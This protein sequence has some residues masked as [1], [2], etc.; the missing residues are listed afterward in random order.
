MTYDAWKTRSPD[1]G[2]PQIALCDRCNAIGNIAEDEY[3]E[4]VC[5]S[6]VDN[7]AE[8]AYERYC[9][10]FHDGGSTRFNSLRDQQIA[11]MKLK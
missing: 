4:F 1:D 2:I 6:C 8:A 10:D 3:G 11:A 9:E 5:A 7:E